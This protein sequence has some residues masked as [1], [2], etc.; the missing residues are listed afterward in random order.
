MESWRPGYGKLYAV[1]RRLAVL[2]CHPHVGRVISILFGD[3]IPNRGVRIY[4]GGDVV[5]AS[6]KASLFWGLYESAEV[7]FIQRYL[8][9]H[10]DVVELGSSLGVVG[11]HVARKLESGFRL[12]C[13][14]PNPSLLPYISRNVLAGCVTTELVVVGAAIDYT[15]AAGTL[16]TLAR[17]GSTI[18]SHLSPKASCGSDSVE[19]PTTTL[20]EIIRANKIGRY[21]LVVDIEGAEAGMLA[22]ES[23]ALM[24]CEQVIVELHDSEWDGQRVSIADMAEW[25]RQ[26]G[27]IEIDRYGPVFVFAR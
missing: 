16:A 19:V 14:E 9:P 10:R 15:R 25:I 4:T 22:M 6:A 3:R 1:K 5:R 7:R 8:A 18:S 2:L 27:F 17:G 11:A 12:I 21:T 26:M 24:S 13:V 23:D 20:A